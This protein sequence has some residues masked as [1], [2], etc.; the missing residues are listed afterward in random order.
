MN[1]VVAG[2]TS[3][4]A[5]SLAGLAVIWPA[6]GRG[7]LPLLARATG[8][9]LGKLAALTALILVVHARAGKDF[10]QPYAVSLAFCVVALLITQAAL[11]AW[12][13]KRLD[14]EGR[15]ETTTKHVHEK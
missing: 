14:G 6:L 11:L 12:R 5:L 1:P 3:G 2:L 8:V 7:L 15:A 9:F 13:L 4:I 10:A